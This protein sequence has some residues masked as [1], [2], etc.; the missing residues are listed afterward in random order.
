VSPPPY[1]VRSTALLSD[2]NEAIVQADV[3]VI[4]LK[5]YALFGEKGV[6][7]GSN[8]TMPGRVYANGNI[9]LSGQSNI[10]FLREVET[11]GTIIGEA[12][13]TYER[14]NRQNI[15]PHPALT[16]LVDFPMYRNA[17]LNAGVCGDGIGLYIG[18]D[19]AAVTAQSNTLFGLGAAFPARIGTNP[20]TGRA[21]TCNG[22]VAS[23][24]QIDLTLFNFAASPI[25][26]GGQPLKAVT[27]ANLTPDTFNGVIYVNGQARVWGILGGRSPEDKTV[28]DN[29]GPAGAPLYNHPEGGVGLVN[30]ALLAGNGGNLYSN[31][32]LDTGEDDDGD[33]E[34]TTAKLGRPINIVVPAPNDIVIDHNVFMGE[35]TTG[36]RVSLGLISGN[37]VYVDE[38]APR[39]L[40]VEASV[41]AMDNVGGTVWTVEGSVET[42][43]AVTR[44]H[45][46]NFWAK[47]GGDAT[48]GAT[49]Q[50]D[51]NQNG[52][53]EANNGDGGTAV[54]SQELNMLTSSVLR[55]NGSLVVAEVP[56]SGAYTVVTPDR[57]R[58]YRYDT[59]LINNEIPCFPTLPRFGTVPG[60]FAEIT[61]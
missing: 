42:Q 17:G 25:T 49:Y 13:A 55:F 4:S 2:G 45:P 40:V 39:T 37:R 54:D 43:G 10:T 30:A 18:T 19:V 52:T 8:I 53:L 29:D 5:D 48:A 60:T 36:T 24:F 59:A 27:G 32:A 16:T 61:R 51:L 41:I 56:S 47:N 12:N 11:T 7:I 46:D 50:F 58:S 21:S 9:N 31:D 28:A 20:V 26:Y 6:S 1:T 14:G 15:T 38:A 33:G 22:G 44:T 3:D 34:L 35:D 23:C 57:P